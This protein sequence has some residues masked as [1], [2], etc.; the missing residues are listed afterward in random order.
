[1]QS[2]RNYNQAFLVIFPGRNINNLSYANDTIL[3]AESEEELKS[4]LM[5][6]KDKSEKAGL[7]LNIQ[8]TKTMTSSHIISWQLNGEK[9]ETV[10]DF[11]FFIFKITTDGDCSHLIKRHLLLGRKAMTNLGILK[12]R[13]Y[14][15]DKDLYSQSYGFSSS[16]VWM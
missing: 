7:K 10:T 6:L 5:K 15:T 4:L 9:V 1:M 12:S 14:F 11:I 3:M 2:L 8:K 13:H 16:H